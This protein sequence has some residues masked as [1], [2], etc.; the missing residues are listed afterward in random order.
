MKTILNSKEYQYC[1]TKK[2]L[3]TNCT[4]AIKIKEIQDILENEVF[5]S[6]NF[7]QGFKVEPIQS[8]LTRE[9]LGL[10]GNTTALAAEIMGHLFRY[11]IYKGSFEKEMYGVDKCLSK[12]DKKYEEKFNEYLSKVLEFRDNRDIITMESMYK[13]FDYVLEMSIF[14]KIYRGEDPNKLF[15]MDIETYNLIIDEVKNISRYTYRYLLKQK[16]VELEQA[17]EKAHEQEVE[18]TWGSDSAWGSQNNSWGKT[19]NIGEEKV[20]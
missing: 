5:L 2:T 19:Y 11:N 20:W 4:S 1:T 18:A 10:V 16:E 14:E 8:I 17:K 12:L 15:D 13:I 9:Y 7:V 3:L 6:C